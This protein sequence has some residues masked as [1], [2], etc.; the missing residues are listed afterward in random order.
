MVKRM[1]AV[2]TVVAVALSPAALL[3]SLY[4]HDRPVPYKSNYTLAC[5]HYAGP[6]CASLNTMFLAGTMLRVVGVALCTFAIGLGAA[7]L[8]R[9]TTRGRVALVSM[10]AATAGGAYALWLSQQALRDYTSLSLLPDR[11]PAGF[12]ERYVARVEQ[13]AQ[14][15]GVWSVAFAL[16]MVIVVIMNVALLWLRTSHLQ[17][18]EPVSSSMR[19][20][21]VGRFILLAVFATVLLT[22]ALVLGAAYEL[23]RPAPCQQQFD[24][25]CASRDAIVTA[26]AVTRGSGVVLFGLGILLGCMVTR[27]PGPQLPLTLGAATL[28]ITSGAWLLWLSQRALEDDASAPFDGASYPLTLLNGS[29]VLVERLALT[30]IAW[31]IGAVALAVILAL[32]TLLF[33]RNGPSSP[34]PPTSRTPALGR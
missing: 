29:V 1:L 9:L 7:L 17:E 32:A 3:G 19:A 15:Y 16:L 24:V 6:P 26:G 27:R 8:L 20:S 13:L 5:E 34:E 28:A 18:G 30:Y 2:G 14:T 4:F 10:I 21:T 11:F 31:S 33:L 25:W 12:F 22:P 23:E